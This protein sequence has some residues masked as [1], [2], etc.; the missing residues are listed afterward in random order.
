MSVFR[1]GVDHGIGVRNGIGLGHGCCAGRGNCADHGNCAGHR[2]RAGRGIGE[3]R[4][5]RRPWPRRRPWHRPDPSFTVDPCA[6]CCVRARARAQASGWWLRRWLSDLLPCRRWS[7]L[8]L[9]PGSY[10]GSYPSL[11]PPRS[12]RSSSS[13]LP[14]LL[15]MHFE[16][17]TAQ[18]ASLATERAMQQVPPASTPCARRRRPWSHLT[19]AL[20]RGDGARRG[21]G[22]GGVADASAA[23]SRPP[24]WR[25]TADDAGA[26]TPSGPMRMAPRHRMSGQSPR[27]A[28]AGSGSALPPISPPPP[29]PTV[30]PATASVGAR[31]GPGG[32]PDPQ[33]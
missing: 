1:W 5:R 9:T 21:P 20:R 12:S 28:A 8:R 13:P 7:P 27:A 23:L 26:E 33:G 4:R 11:A 25:L 30:S 19:P 14:F 32:R 24:A 29:R 17:A 16:G 10:V 15:L 6:L 18:P 31:E 3:V 2:I 22:A